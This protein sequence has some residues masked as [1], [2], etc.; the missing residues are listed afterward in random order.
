MVQWLR[1]LEAGQDGYSGSTPGQVRSHVPQ[2]NE[3]HEPQL[4]RPAHLGPVLRKKRAHRDEKP[5][6][7][8]W[9]KPASSDEDP[10]QPEIINVF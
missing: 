4:L 8:N 9:K 5:A 6:R 10:G 7:H 3:A 2:S 1:I